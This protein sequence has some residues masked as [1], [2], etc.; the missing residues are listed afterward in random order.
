MM[1]KP[2]KQSPALPAAVAALM[3]PLVRLLVANGITLPTM[4]EMLKASYVRVAERHFG[5]DGAPPTDTRVA[6]LTGV[7]RKDVRRLRAQ[8]I[9]AAPAFQELNE[10]SE[11]VTRWVSDRRYLGRDGRPR[12]LPRHS[13][14]GVVHSFD[15][16]A[17][18]VSSDLKPRTILDELT[19]LGMARVE[20]DRIVLEVD[21]FVPERGSSEAAFFFGENIRDHIA[22]AARNIEGT[23]APFLE[24]A[25]YSDDL[26]HESVEEL[27]TLSRD[28]WAEVLKEIV[29]RAGELEDHDRA[30]GRATERMNLGIYFY[31]EPTARS[32]RPKRAR[33]SFSKQRRRK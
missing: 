1:G 22:A 10:M 9:D 30:D 24:Q 12:P 4:V 3:G 31:S 19:R 2:A 18:G 17:Y 32:T 33:A 14:R 5:L 6:L 11:V 23:S 8:P 20:D 7:H 21:A 13:S 16:L 26:S 29:R 25:V 27:H 15:S 28:L